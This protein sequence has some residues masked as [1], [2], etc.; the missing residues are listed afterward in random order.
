MI[1]ARKIIVHQRS[2]GHNFYCNPILGRAPLLNILKDFPR[3]FVMYLMIRHLALP[4]RNLESR[5]VIS[6]QNRSLVAIART[7]CRRFRTAAPDGGKN[8]QQHDI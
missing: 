5:P 8:R 3:K 2:Y 6:L 4:G 1:R 7:P